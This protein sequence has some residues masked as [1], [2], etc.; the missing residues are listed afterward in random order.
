[1]RLSRAKRMGGIIA[2]ALLM[3]AAPARPQAPAQQ[4]NPSGKAA[5]EQPTAAPN[6]IVREE[7]EDLAE[8][9]SAITAD[10]GQPLD[11]EELPESMR[12]LYRTGDYTDLPAG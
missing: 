5:Q 6:R 2:L 3:G 1:M 12:P 11:R 10:I 9:P 8:S 7:G 4:E